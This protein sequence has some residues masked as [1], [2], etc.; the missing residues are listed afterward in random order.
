TCG[1]ER[2]GRRLEV[3]VDRKAKSVIA[4][5]TERYALEASIDEPRLPVGGERRVTWRVENRA[6]RPLPV[7][8]LAEGEDAVRCAFQASAVLEGT[9]EWSATV[10]AEQPAAPVPPTRQG[11]PGRRAGVGDG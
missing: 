7:T 10:T 5:E 1:G 6:S 3:V 8:I 2:D 4:L 11:N 9:R